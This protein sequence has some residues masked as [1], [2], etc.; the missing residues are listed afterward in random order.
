MVCVL[1]IAPSRPPD[2]TFGDYEDYDGNT[3]AHKSFVI[4]SSWTWNLTVVIMLSVF[5][6]AANAA[7]LLV[8]TAPMS[9]TSNDVTTK[10]GV[11]IGPCVE[12]VDTYSK[13][14]SN[15]LQADLNTKYRQIRFEGL[16]GGVTRL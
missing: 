14:W 15:D 1:P 6:I 8:R 9:P 12:T 5:G 10:K 7:L 16:H 11:R 3:S 13:A 2:A 4:E